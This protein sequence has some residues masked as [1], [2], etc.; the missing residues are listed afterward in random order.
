MYFDGLV[1]SNKVF[2]EYSFYVS[3]RIDVV[4]DI[5]EVQI[6]VSFWFYLD[7]YFIEF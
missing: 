1:I 4:V 2:L 5:L 3:G 6:S 7:V